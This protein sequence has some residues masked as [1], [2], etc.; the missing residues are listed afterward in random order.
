MEHLLQKLNPRHFQILDYALRGFSQKDIAEALGM[1]TQMISIVMRSPNFQHELS[2]RRATVDAQRA[3]SLAEGRDDPVLDQ[4]KRGAVMAAKRLVVNTQDTNG[5]VA[6]K[7]CAEILDRTGFQTVQKHSV[8]SK[9]IT[10]NID[11]SD[12]SRITETLRMLHSAG[13]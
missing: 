13:A 7:A 1:S 3:E 8:E 11:A 5:S 12:A 10:L 9:S 2:L 4:L 6:N